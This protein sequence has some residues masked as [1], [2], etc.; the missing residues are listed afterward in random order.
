MGATIWNGAP[1]GPCGVCG[2]M[3]HLSQNCNV[4]SQ[5][6][7]H[8]DAKFVHD[9]R[10]NFNP[11]SNTQNPGWRSHSN[12]SCSNNQHQG[13]PRYYQSQQQAPQEK[14]SNL[15]DMLSKF[16]T[17]ANTRFQNQDASIQNLEVQVGQLVS[18]VSE[19]KESQL[20]SDTEKN[21][22][23][24]VNAITVRQERASGHE[25]SKEQ[26]EETQVQKEEEPLLK[27]KRKGVILNSI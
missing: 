23:E 16:I 17:V 5:F 4:G 3:R 12:F 25:S 20:P 1:I 22:R 18:I 2:Q 10:S 27:R 26:V 9:G 14:K 13:P 7:I 6:S 8:E 15:E 19:R 24:Q 11:Y 21:P